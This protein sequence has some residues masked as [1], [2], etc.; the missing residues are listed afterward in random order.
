MTNEDKPSIH[1]SVLSAITNGTVRMR[2]H[3]H[4]VLRSLGLALG[5]FFAGAFGV[6][7]ISFL[8]FALH[9]SGAWFVPPLGMMGISV[10]VRSFPWFLMGVIVIAVVLLE[11]LVRRYAF[12]YRKPVLYSSLVIVFVVIL[13][14][15]TLAQTSVHRFMFQR[16]QSNTLPFAGPLYRDYGTRRSGHVVS[17]VVR[18]VSPKGYVVELSPGELVVVATTSETRSWGRMM[19]APG[20]EIVVVG[21]AQRGMLRAQGIRKIMP[22]SRIMHGPTAGA[23][24]ER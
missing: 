20:D 7:L 13:G 2:P 23:R 14:G 16:A 21:S 9:Q 15:F 8:V 3:W 18:E 6:F 19:I 12:A 17:G 22:G 24:L 1:A 11:A 4:F 10:L 5:V